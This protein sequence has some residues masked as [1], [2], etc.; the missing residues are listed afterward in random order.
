MLLINHRVCI[1]LLKNHSVYTYIY[2]VVNKPQAPP[3]VPMH[4][5]PQGLVRTLLRCMMQGGFVGLAS[6]TITQKHKQTKNIQILPLTECCVAIGLDNKH[7]TRRGFLH[8]A[9]LND[10]EVG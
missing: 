3:A 1:V 4:A 8:T 7:K 6:M 5:T 10:A 2:C 9:T